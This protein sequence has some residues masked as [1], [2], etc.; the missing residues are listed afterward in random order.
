LRKCTVHLGSAHSRARP[1]WPSGPAYALAWH[2][3][4]AHGED[5]GGEIPSDAG[6]SPA[7]FGRS[8]AVGRRGSSQGVNP[9]NGDP[10]LVR[11]AAGGS[12]W[13]AHSGDGN[14]AEGFV[15]EGVG[16]LS[17]AWLVRL[18]STSELRRCY[19]WGRWGRRSTRGGGRW[20]SGKSG[21]GEVERSGGSSTTTVG[22]GV[23]SFSSG[24]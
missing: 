9:V 1:A 16:R 21:D 3:L 20:W 5:R 12:P 11:R 6:G 18:E 17:L 23:N 8:A 10:D 13:R 2:G 14:L 15:G 24:Q 4:A 7:K 19:G 22:R